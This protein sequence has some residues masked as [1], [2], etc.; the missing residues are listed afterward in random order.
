MAQPSADEM[1]EELMHG[2]DRAR[3]AGQERRAALAELQSMNVDASAPD[4]SVSVTVTA[5]GVMT[6]LRLDER[7]DGLRPTDIA[8]LVLSTYLSAQRAAAVKAIELA[9]VALGEHDYLHRRL[10][11][12]KAFVPAA[13]RPQRPSVIEDDEENTASFFR[14]L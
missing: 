12:R 7:V 2:F 13:Q 1:F 10:H 11:W 3:K 5:D 9:V 6:D 14:N 4:G 8:A